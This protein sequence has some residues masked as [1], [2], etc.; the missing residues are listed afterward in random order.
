MPEEERGLGSRAM[1]KG[2]ESAEID[3]KSKNSNER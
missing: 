3:E 2:E 1:T